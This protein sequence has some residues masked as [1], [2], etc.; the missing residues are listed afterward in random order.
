[1]APSGELEVPRGVRL[2]TKTYSKQI[3]I[4]LVYDWGLDTG[5]NAYRVEPS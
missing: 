5:F 4:H 1:M 2:Q 3:V